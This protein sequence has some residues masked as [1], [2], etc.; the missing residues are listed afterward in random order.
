MEFRHVCTAAAVLSLPFGLGFVLAPAAMAA[1]YAVVPADPTTLL[2]G[3]YFGSE[4]LMYAAAA[5][6]LRGLRTANE[7]RAAAGALAAATLTGLAVTLQAVLAGTL[8]ALGWTSVALYGGFAL[9]WA[10]LAL[11]RADVGRA[12]VRH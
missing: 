1:A 8:N 12:V 5:W 3:R 2:I 7:Q 9:A 6:G 11:R 10:T 4:T